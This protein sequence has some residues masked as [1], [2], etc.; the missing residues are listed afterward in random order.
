VAW[1]NA[2]VCRDWSCDA[3]APLGLPPA[4]LPAP[5]RA[6]TCLALSP[7]FA[8]AFDL[9]PDATDRGGAVLLARPRLDPAAARGAVFLSRE[10][11]VV[12]RVL[13]AAP[14]LET[15]VFHGPAHVPSAQEVAVL[16]QWQRVPDPHGLPPAPV[17][18]LLADGPRLFVAWDNRVYAV[19]HAASPDAR[20]RVVASLHNVLADDNLVR[21]DVNLVLAAGR[22]VVVCGTHVYVVDAARFDAQPFYLRHAFV[23][24]PAPLLRAAWLGPCLV[25]VTDATAPAP[26][27]DCEQD[28]AAAP[29]GCCVRLHDPEQFRTVS[30]FALPAAAGRV[31]STWF[32]GRFF[33]IK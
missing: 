22:L 15:P 11:G 17:R 29:L 2:V 27:S 16:A 25:T 14:S 3:L 6:V 24:P 28:A 18:R 21:P 13:L 20:P 19:A 12:V 32:D 9:A 1:I 23:H 5:H 10:P 30:E 7:D 31:T 33:F 8:A 4:S 26:L